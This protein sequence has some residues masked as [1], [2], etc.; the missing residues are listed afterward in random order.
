[1][2]AERTKRSGA[3]TASFSLVTAL[4][5][6]S[7]LWP[8]AARGQAQNDQ[9]SATPSPVVPENP[10]SPAQLPPSG[11]LYGMPRITPQSPQ[12]TT[13]GTTEAA[14]ATGYSG[15]D[16]I[17]T[18][19]QPALYGGVRRA[20]PI[21][22]EHVIKKGETLWEISSYYYNDPWMWP[23]L[24]A[25]NPSITNPHWIY[26]GD[27][28]KMLG[29]GERPKPSGKSKSRVEVVR[30]RVS[31][32]PDAG[33]M[34]VRQYAFVDPKEMSKSGKIVG[35]RLERRMIA[36]F[37][38]FYARGSGFKPSPGK[39]YMVYRVRK[40]L[41]LDGKK[42]AGHVVEVVGTAKV[43]SVKRDGVATLQVTDMF[44]VIRRGYRVGPVRTV[45]K[46]LPVT[47]AEKN[48]DAK[49][50][51]NFAPKKYIADDE[52][53]FVNR[54]RKQGVHEGNRFFVVR[55][56]DGIRRIYQDL[57]KDNQAFP[58]ETV[59]EVRVLD[60]RDDVSVAYVVHSTME[61]RDGDLLKMRRGK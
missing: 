61:L 5:A 19:S 38:E 29:A 45:Y 17:I 14:P 7:L 57:E 36:T 49:L 51:A 1:M 2:A 40:P 47:P 44:N 33:V 21:P 42:V 39:G 31:R 28:I 50:I 22:K 8:A 43:V 46:K 25:N 30:L 52:L 41:E 35:S 37:D 18:D 54:G 6:C 16:M 56:G 11:A 3:P 32:R 26:P 23:Q 34:K 27:R 4:A 13:G 48:L 20:V 24:W 60:A 58:Y 55:R 53:V 59:G 9:P 12:R 15:G 10:S